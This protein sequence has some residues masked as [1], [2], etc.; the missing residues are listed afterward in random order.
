MNSK[1]NNISQEQDTEKLKDIPKWTHKYAQNRALPVLI[2]LA[3][4]SC[5]FMGFAIS[6]HFGGRAYRAGNMVIFWI[7]V[8]VSSIAM[9]SVFF[10]SVPRWGGK[11][12]E[13]ISQ[14][15]Y[16]REGNVLISGP[17]VMKKKKWLVYVVGMIF[18][19][20][21]GTSCSYMFRFCGV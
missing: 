17:E 21:V 3:I 13:R 9:I 11:F 8:F 12:I 1:Q 16:G 15:L 19:S 14:R 10:F 2:S 5:I 18:C 7:C 4:F 20:C 6:A